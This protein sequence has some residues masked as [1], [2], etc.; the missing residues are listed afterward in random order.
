MLFIN[1]IFHQNNLNLA[2]WQETNADIRLV[3]TFDVTNVI[4][5]T[6]SIIHWCLESLILPNIIA[7]F[8]IFFNII[9]HIKTTVKAT[10]VN[11][12]TL[13]GH[14]VMAKLEWTPSYSTIY[15][16]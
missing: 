1:D 16:Q 3:L 15:Y 7:L 8:I 9:V 14:T 12:S 13:V 5:N 10:S 11:V 4:T 6:S 2:L